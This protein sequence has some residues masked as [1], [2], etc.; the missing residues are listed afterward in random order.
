MTAGNAAIAANTGRIARHL[1][2]VVADGGD[3]ISVQAA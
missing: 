1:D 3:A 2:N